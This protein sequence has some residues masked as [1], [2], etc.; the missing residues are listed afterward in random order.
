VYIACGY[1]CRFFG[2]V[3]RLLRYASADLTTEIQLTYTLIA[4]MEHMSMKRR[5]EGPEG[6]ERLVEA[7]KRQRLVEND[8]DLAIA[9]AEAGEVVEFLAGEQFITQGEVD[10]DAFFIIDGQAEV[11]INGRRVAI[12][13]SR[14]CVGEMALI[15]HAVRRS[16]T[17]IAA[18]PLTAL[19]IAEAKFKSITANNAVVWRSL[20]IAIADRLRERAKFHRPPNKNPVLFIGSSVEGVALA[21][22]IHVALQHTR[23]VV[24]LWNVNGVFGPGGTNIQSLMDEVHQADFA[25]FIFGPDDKLFSRKQE[26]DVPRDNVVFEL[27]LFMGQ[28]EPHRSFIVKD[29]HADIKLPS[30]LGGVIPVTYVSGEGRDLASLA[31][32][33]ATQLQGVIERTGVR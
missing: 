9:L 18:S 7:L 4:S 27:G 29:H 12:R 15:D 17:V 31:K 5:F 13:S 19:K 28:L 20:A 2:V 24:R 11:W 32:S 16:A 23:I 8:H 30:D 22:E 1:L 33:V 10:N 26:Y 21:N 3:A 6:R 25:A 14:E